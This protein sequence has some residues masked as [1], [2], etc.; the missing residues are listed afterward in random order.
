MNERYEQ[1]AAQIKEGTIWA[2]LPIENV[3]SL[4]EQFEQVRKEV[5]SS[6]KLDK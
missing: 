2:D 6:L 5:L 3:E 4:L 1:L